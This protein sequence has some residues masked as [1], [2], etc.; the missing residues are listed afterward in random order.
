MSCDKIYIRLYAN[1]VINA[2]FINDE[3]IQMNFK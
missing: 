3:Y 1:V 2:I